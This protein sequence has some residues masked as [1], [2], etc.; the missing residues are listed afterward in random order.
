MDNKYKAAFALAFL[1]IIYT[2]YTILLQ[3]GG[4]TIGILP[5]LFYAFLIGMVVSAAV[6][7][8]LD[9][10]KAL[11]EILG[12]PNLLLAVLAIG[13]VNN[14]LTQLF[15]GFGTLGTNASVASVVYRSWVIMAILLVPLVLRQKIRKMQLLATLV[16]FSGLYLIISGGTLIGINYSQAPFIGLVLLSALCSAI[17]TLIYARYTFN[18]F[19]GIVFYNLVSLVMVGSLAF[20][21]GTSLAVTFPPS[22]LFSVLFYGIFGF[23]IATSLYYYS[24]KV[25]GPQ[26]VGNS[27]LVVPFVTILLS[28]ILVATP[29]QPYYI[30]AALLISVGVLIQR[31]YSRSAERI[32]KNKVLDKFTIFD[33][34]GAFVGNKSPFI[35]DSIAGEN[36]AFAIRLNG[37]KIEDKSHRDLFS[38]YGCTSFTNR[39]PHA[40]TTPD[41]MATI[42]DALKLNKGETA[43]IGLGNPD[44]L[45]DAFAE[46][47]S[48]PENSPKQS[49]T[50]WRK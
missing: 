32:T 41:E 23:G 2:L 25:L 48:N 45:E 31:Y 18:I 16:G 14:A 44:R 20:A 47:V 33:V 42:G 6:S 24:V 21:T 12:K 43:L 1:V 50:E 3:I 34:T 30:I 28:A 8:A 39:K 13:L 17:V 35:A 5:Q 29:I 37:G 27:I 10:G 19:A 4:S 36:R 49:D 9:G 11:R 7:L 26:T 38:K 40:A 15:L 46:F 22:A